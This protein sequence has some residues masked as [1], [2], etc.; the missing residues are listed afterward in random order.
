MTQIARHRWLVPSVVAACCVA[1]LIIKL[2][3]NRWRV[4]PGHGDVS[5]YFNVAR[6]LVE[7]RGFSLDYISGFWGRPEGLPTP[8]N[9]WWMPLVSIIAAIGMWLGQPDYASAQ[10]ATTCFSSLLP[11]IVYLLGRD[12]FE[13]RRTGLI[14][15]LLSTTFFLFL[16]QPSA[17]ISASPYVVLVP[18][19]LWLCLHVA[20]RPRLLLAAG[21]ALALTQ[22]TRTDG[23]LLLGSILTG[24]LLQPRR[25]DAPRN[26][27]RCFGLLALGYVLVIC[28]WWLR[29]LSEFG[30]LQP[31]VSARALFM[32]SYSDWTA[33]PESVN[34]QNWLQDGWQPI[35]AGKAKVGLAN[36]EAL[37]TGMTSGAFQQTLAWNSLA[38]TGLMVLSWIGLPGSFRRRFLPIW[39]FALLAWLFYSVAFSVVGRGSFRSAMYGLYPF[40]LICAGRGLEYIAGWLAARAP[41]NWRERVCTTVLVGSVALFMLGHYQFAS[42]SLYLKGQAIS[43]RAQFY[44]ALESQLLQPLGLQDAVFM[45]TDVHEF[46]ALLRRPCVQLPSEDAAT[47]LSTARRLGV[48]HLLL[49]GEFMNQNKHLLRIAERDDVSN[50]HGPR[51]LGR[52]LVRILALD[53]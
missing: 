18:L 47:I 45:T 50:L 6:S 8:S 25:T 39:C 4:E 29:N 43:Q 46:H 1:T 17:P 15:A 22:L 37:L 2:H 19:T 28:P 36:L 33:L 51:L 41:T 24:L 12:I 48:T 38:V 3:L 5:A 44:R 26:L 49:L 21:A 52:E 11:W 34:L 16:G 13:S 20:E 31:S 7:G 9:L 30:T 40:Q 10:I 53:Q 42:K 32:H 23:L 35:L 14:G 27:M